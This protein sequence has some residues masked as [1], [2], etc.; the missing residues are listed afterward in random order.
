MGLRSS[1]E[2]MLV[3]GRPC[4]QGMG[5]WK[6]LMLLQVHGVQRREAEGER[7]YFLG[8]SSKFWGKNN[9]G[10]TS[11]E[12]DVEGRKVAPARWL[13][14]PCAPPSSM[15]QALAQLSAALWIERQL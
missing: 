2:K 12:T 1:P 15:P 6:D 3:G 14:Q 11:H 5:A 4:Q 9:S 7:N 13:L 8:A 10:F